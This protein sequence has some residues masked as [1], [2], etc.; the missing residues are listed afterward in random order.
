[1]RSIQSIVDIKPFVLTLKFN[2]DEVLSINLAPKLEEWAV[3]PDSIYH[4]LLQPDYFQTVQYDAEWE[5]I[6][7]DNGIDFCA[8]MLFHSEGASFE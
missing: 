8:D 2:T 6:Y 5:S 7:W 4:Q 1:M 3:T